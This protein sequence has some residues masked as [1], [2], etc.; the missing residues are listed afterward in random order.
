MSVYKRKGADTYSY[1]FWVQG[2]RFTGDTGATSKRE[3][4]TVEG[5]RKDEAKAQLRLDKAAL[6][7]AGDMTFEIAYSRWWDE[8]GRHNNPR[9]HETTLRNLDWLVSRLGASRLLTLIDDN[10]VASLVAKRRGEHIQGNKKLGLVSAAT[11][12]RTC[13]QP[14]REIILRAKKVWKV[15]VGDVSFGLHILPE[16]QER[17]R[18]ASVDEEQAIME[19]LE[20]GYDVAIQ[21]AFLTGCRRMEILALEWPHVDFFS[22]RFTV[23]GKGQKSRTIPMSQAIFDLLWAEKNHHP[24]KVFT[25]IAK[26][27]K[28]WLGYVKGKRYPLT[29]SGLKSSMR[30]AVPNASVKDFRFHDT[31]HTAATRTLRTSNLRVVQRLLGHANV[32]TTAKYAHAMDEDIRAALDAV[33]DAVSPTQNPAKKRFTHRKTLRMNDKTD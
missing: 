18:E 7:T 32:E 10:V 33:S 29:E 16:P 5:Q 22:R 12:N 17:V 20:R 28:K 25:F 19:Q 3:A 21:F 30:R 23:T 24:E 2:R 6:S 27:T 31:R 9:G 11:V 8:V 14:L 13:T 26:R 4:G 15:P 1:D